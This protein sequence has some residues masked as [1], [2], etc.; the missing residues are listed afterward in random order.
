M[1]SQDLSDGQEKRGMRRAIRSGVSWVKSAFGR[2]SSDPPTSAQAEVDNTKQME[3]DDTEWNQLRNSLRVLEIGVELFPPLKSAVGAFIECL[4]IIQTAASN[5]EDYKELAVEFHSM[6]NMINQYVGELGSEPKNGSIANITEC[7]QH[8]LTCIRQKQQCKTVRRL[9]DANDDQEDLVRHYRQVERLF[10]QIQCDLSMRTRSD[11][12]KQLETERR[13]Q[14]T[15]LR[16]ML[17]VDDAKYNSSYSTT[18]RRHRC[19]AK[20]RE[21][22]HQTLRDWTTNPKSE[23]I[24]WMNG[25][26]G[27]GKTTIAYSYCEWLEVS[28]RLGASFF[29][30][31]ISSTCRSLNQI[32]P[33]L[34]YQLARF[35][36]AFRSRLCTTLNHDPDAGKLNVVQQF[37]KLIYQPVLDAKDAMPDSVVVVIDAL[38]ECDDN[39]SVRLLLE[40]LLKFAD[41]LPLKVF[42]SSRPEPV[43]RDR[44][45]S[46]G[47][48]SRFI[49]YLHDI[50]Q[51][52]VEEDIKKYLTKELGSMEHPPFPGQIELL[53]KRS[54]NLFIYAATVV[55]YIYPDDIPVD[56]GARLKLMLEA[57]GNVRGMS[58]NRYE[59]L[60]FLYT[61]VLSAVFKSRLGNREKDQI[62]YVLW[63][64][65]ASKNAKCR[66]PSSRSDL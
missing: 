55:R 31:R 28:N 24:Y 49:V 3:S 45:M 62:R 58:D 34:A 54:R 60:D 66:P 9:V 44:M 61:T 18:I 30:S 2:P 33:T 21:A 26:A 16:N 65:R 59:D 4:A 43:I 22:I 53:A 32:I 15:L 19:T 38:D 41:H 64:V 36:P 6:A 20:T 51:S 42:V 8:Q 40:V 57:V 39:H 47:G 37:E 14:T 46:R 25:M 63:T 17:P 52:I 11:I 35:S 13:E 56:S 5:R 48:S 29:C 10:R 50:E 12:K 7:I 1:S 27:T 23:K